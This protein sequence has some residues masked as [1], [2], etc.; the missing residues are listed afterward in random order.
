MAGWP[1]RRSSPPASSSSPAR[2]PPTAYVD[3]PKLVRETIID[4]G[5][6]DGDVRL[7]RQHLR[8]HHLD[9]RAVARHRPGRRH[10]PRDPHRHLRRGRPQRPGRRRPGD[11][12][13]LRLRRDRRPHAAAD[14]AGPPPRRAAG[15]GPQGRHRAATC[16]PTARPRSPSTTRTASP[17]RAASTVLISTQHDAGRRPRDQIKPDLH[18]ARHRR[19]SSP[20]SSPATTTTVLRQPDR[21]LRARRPARRRRPHRPQDHRRH[22]RR[23]GPPRRRRLLRQGPVEGRPLGRLRRPLGGQE[24]R[25]RRRRRPVRD[26]GGLRHRRGPPRLDHG[27]D[28]RHRAR[29]TPSA[30]RRRP[31]TRSSTSARPP[32]SATSTCAGPIYRKTAAYG[33]FGRNEPGFTWE[34][35]HASVTCAPP[36]ACRP[37]HGTR[38]AGEPVGFP[39]VIVPDDLRYTSDHEW[40]RKEDDGRLRIGITD[41]AQDALG[42]VVFVQLPDVGAAFEVE[43]RLFRGGVHQVGQ[44]RLRPGGRHGRRGQRRPGRRAPAPQRGPLRRGVDLRASS[45]PTPRPTT[46]SSTPPRTA[47]SP[48]A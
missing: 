18:R 46:G 2:S 27:R 6:D 30:D 12:V 38:H 45:P 41:Y 26:P 4:I 19:R 34:Q 24:R 32:S 29:S 20:S 28:V 22:L 13:R 17:S 10:R 44:R 21:Q 40:V 9:R 8:R 14:L 25:G 39:G 31:S 37:V 1:A 7:R 15:R 16:G 23:R 42:D 35:T 48:S 36:W 5:Y 33:H 43:R 11:D 47:I 3:I